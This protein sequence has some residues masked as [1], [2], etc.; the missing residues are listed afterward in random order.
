MG[1]SHCCK[2]WDR[3]CLFVSDHLS[4]NL[5]TVS[6]LEDSVFPTPSYLHIPEYRVV[7]FI[8]QYDKENAF[9]L[10]NSQMVDV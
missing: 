9:T 5:C 7:L 8:V 1:L 10:G 2:S 6:D 3:D 4:K